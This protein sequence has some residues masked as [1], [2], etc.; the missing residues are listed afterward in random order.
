M[1]TSRYITKSITTTKGVLIM[2]KKVYYIY[3]RGV[4]I[5]TRLFDSKETST[6]VFCTLLNDFGMD[7]IGY[8]TNLLKVQ[9]LFLDSI[10]YDTYKV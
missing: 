3:V 5:T 10:Y 9:Q 7:L 4:G 2:T 6:D 8:D 1:D